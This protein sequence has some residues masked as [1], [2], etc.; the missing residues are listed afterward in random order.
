MLHQMHVTGLFRN[1]F[2][3]L[4]HFYR[5]NCFICRFLFQLNAR[6]SNGNWKMNLLAKFYNIYQ[7]E[8]DVIVDEAWQ[9]LFQ[10]FF[11]LFVSSGLHHF[12]VHCPQWKYCKVLLCDQDRW[13]VR[14][15]ASDTKSPEQTRAYQLLKAIWKLIDT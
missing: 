6:L 13:M 9:N 15:S 8:L 7:E 12:S 4:K 2:P 1:S 14:Y 10:Y 5:Q 3:L 11:L